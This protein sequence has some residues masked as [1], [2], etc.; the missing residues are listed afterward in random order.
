MS[1]SREVIANA[2][3]VSEEEVKCENCKAFSG[4]LWCKAWEQ[5][6]RSKDFCTFFDMRGESDG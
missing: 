5:P 3:K 6:T 4:W 1:V 2:I